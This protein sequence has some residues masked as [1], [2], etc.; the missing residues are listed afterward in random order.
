MFSYPKKRPKVNRLQLFMELL[1]YIVDVI[2]REHP[3]AE[4]LLLVELLL[5]DSGVD[6]SRDLTA[7]WL[8][9]WSMPP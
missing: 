1:E 4:G 9:S 7:A 3:D 8:I 6:Y 5:F 2:L